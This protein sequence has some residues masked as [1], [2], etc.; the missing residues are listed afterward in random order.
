M[1]L[2]TNSSKD[3]NAFI[4][5]VPD[6]ITT[7]S[8][9]LCNLLSMSSSKIDGTYHNIGVFMRHILSH[10]HISCKPS[11]D[12]FPAHVNNNMP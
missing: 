11:T 3:P 7:N 4:T 9:P 8:I 5:Q 2:G 6:N 12:I 10:G 1:P